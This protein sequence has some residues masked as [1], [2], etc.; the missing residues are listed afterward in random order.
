[1][2]D[3]IVQAIAD[4]FLTIMTITGSFKVSTPSKNIKSASTGNLRFVLTGALS[5]SRKEVAKDIEAAGH[6]MDKTI[7]GKTDYLVAGN[8][9]WGSKHK[10]AEKLGVKVIN[11]EEL[12]K[13]L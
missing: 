9:P 5:K 3:V 4:N 6:T 7:T 10:K 2:A 8:G 1:M 13:L 12:L 11:E